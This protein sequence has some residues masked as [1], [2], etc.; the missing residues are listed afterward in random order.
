MTRAR[1]DLVRPADAV[2]E[3]VAERVTGGDA[4]QLRQ[5]HADDRDLDQC[6]QLR[7]AGG[8]RTAS[9]NDAE[10]RT[11]PA[12]E[13]GD[14][15]DQVALA[16][17]VALPQHR[18]SAGGMERDGLPPVAFEHL[19][20]KLVR[21]ED[22]GGGALPVDLLQAAVHDRQQHRVLVGGREAAA[23]EEREHAFGERDRVRT[24][25][26]WVAHPAARKRE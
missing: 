2:H 6:S 23:V 24:G 12:A 7:E 20:G 21:V 18:W 5:R 15:R 8:I 16:A 11:D 9:L 14:P 19:G 25:S 1:A 17:L 10:L 26:C 3:A 13:L 4:L 22:R